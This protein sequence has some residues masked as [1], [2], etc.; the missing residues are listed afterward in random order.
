MSNNSKNIKYKNDNERKHMT[1]S[2]AIVPFFKDDV[3]TSFKRCLRGA[4]IKPYSELQRKQTT[5]K[6]AELLEKRQNH[7]NKFY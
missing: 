5:D 4:S 7:N 1:V 3:A 2:I 6:I